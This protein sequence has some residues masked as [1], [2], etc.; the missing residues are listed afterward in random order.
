MPQRHRQTA[1]R[2]RFRSTHPPDRIHAPNAT[3][4][5]TASPTSFLQQ[6]SSALLAKVWFR[7]DYVRRLVELSRGQRLSLIVY[8]IWP[9]LGSGSPFSKQTRPPQHTLL[10]TW[11]PHTGHTLRHNPMCALLGEVGVNNRRL[12]E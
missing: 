11:S 8:T 1:S 5:L 10:P 6:C 2:H 12:Q 3:P 7:P 9:G 4:H